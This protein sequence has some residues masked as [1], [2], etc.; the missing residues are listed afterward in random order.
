RTRRS[1]R[2]LPCWISSGSGAGTGGGSWAGFVR[3]IRQPGEVVEAPVE[4]A[5]LLPGAALVAEV[6]VGQRIVIERHDAG[7]ADLG[8][9]WGPFERLDRDQLAIGALRDPFAAGGVVEGGDSLD[10]E[11]LHARVGGILVQG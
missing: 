8:E 6:G 9:E 5:A 2:R 1:F 3:R 10:E 11:H 7:P 4:V